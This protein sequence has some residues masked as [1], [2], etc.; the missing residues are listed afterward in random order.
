MLFK[1]ISIKDIKSGKGAVLGLIGLPNEMLVYLFSFLDKESILKLRK[2]CSRFLA[3]T[4]IPLARCFQVSWEFCQSVG[5]SPLE[6]VHFRP[7]LYLANLTVPLSQSTYAQRLIKSFGLT[8]SNV[9]SFLQLHPDGDEPIPFDFYQSDF[10]LATILKDRTIFLLKNEPFDVSDESTKICRINNL[11]ALVNRG[12]ALFALTEDMMCTIVS[13]EELQTRTLPDVPISEKRKRV[14]QNKNGIFFMTEKGQ[15]KP[16]G[17]TSPQNQFPRIPD[18][19]RLEKVVCSNCMY[20]AL[21][22]NS[23]I[24]FWGGRSRGIKQKIIPSGRRVLQLESNP[25]SFIALLDNQTVVHWGDLKQNVENKYHI[26]YDGK[27]LVSSKNDN[28]FPQLQFSKFNHL[29]FKLPTGAYIYKIFSNEFAYVAIL[30]SG[31]LLGW[32]D[33]SYGSDVPKI[34]ENRTVKEVV[35]NERAFVVLLDNGKMLV[36]GSDGYGGK[37][38]FL[39][40]NR[41]VKT[42]FSNSS[43]FVVLLDDGSIVPWGDRRFGGGTPCMP[44]DYVVKSIFSNELGYVAVLD[45]G[46]PVL[47]V[48][49]YNPSDDLKISNDRTIKNVYPHGAGFIFQLDNDDYIAWGWTANPFFYDSQSYCKYFRLSDNAVAKLDDYYDTENGLS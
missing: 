21:L 27:R 13:P 30:K 12:Y 47:L 22:D 26:S 15:L 29:E 40:E 16:N 36:W 33:S 42:I 6:L 17:R 34:P 28:S 4:D 11:R 37:C 43:S 35:A 38:P 39:P 8:P 19:R 46:R 45:T 2:V 49:S 1:L 41:T 44:S 10:T 20:V 25:N 3:H 7:T 5:M 48:P 18:G 32:G 14:Y 31:K 24:L 23:E 9:H